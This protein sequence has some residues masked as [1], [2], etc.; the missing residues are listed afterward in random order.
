MAEARRFRSVYVGL[1]SNL[2]Q[3]VRQVLAALNELDS[4]PETDVVARSS[5]YRSAPVGKLDQ[6]DFV[7]AVARLDTSLPAAE[8][9]RELHAIE[10]KHGRVRGEPNAARTLDIDLLLFGADVVRQASLT[11]PH[12]RMH[13][14][15]F[16]LVPLA[17][18]SADAVIPGRG[19]VASLL[20][21][22]ADQCL[23]KIDADQES[24]LHRS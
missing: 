20:A 7:N 6:P 5:L 19:A 1:G 15:A 3:P 2:E 18:I 23:K 11:V 24:S 14:R 22:V 16:V 17:E 8:L 21:Q 13:E 4:L 12:P 9:M 10:A